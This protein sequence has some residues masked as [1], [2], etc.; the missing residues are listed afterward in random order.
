VLILKDFELIP[1]EFSA[2]TVK[3]DVPTVVGVPEIVPLFAFNVKP[4]GIVPPETDQAI[5][6]DPLALSL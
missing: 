1:M 6:V 3:Y 4:G 5:G 2:L